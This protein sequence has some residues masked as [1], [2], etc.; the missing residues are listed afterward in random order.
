MSL[1]NRFLFFTLL[2][3]M[4]ILIPS[5]SSLSP[6][7]TE[8]LW[9]FFISSPEKSSFQKAIAISKARGEALD[10][11]TFFTKKETSDS[12]KEPEKAADKFKKAIQL[13]AD[14]NDIMK[15]F[16]DHP[17]KFLFGVSSSAYQYEG[18]LD[19]WNAN[20]AFYR[21]KG[22]KLADHAIDFWNSYENDIQQMKKEL[23]IN[24]FRLSIA[25]DRIQPGIR[26][27][28]RN[29]IDRYVKIIETLKN[30]N[31]EPI[32][33]L[34]H[35]TIPQ[36]FAEIGGFEKAENISYFVDFAK[37]MY[38]ALHE[39]VTYWSTFNAIEGYAFKGY[40][41]LDGPPGDPK[42][43][44]LF[45]TEKVMYNM[46][47][48]HQQCYD[49]IKELFAHYKN[50]SMIPN[51]Q[52]GIQK[53]IV[54]FDPFQNEKTSFCEKYGSK[55]I[56]SFSSLL[57]NTIFFKF[58]K[59]TRLIRYFNLC[60]LDWIGLNIYSNMMMLYAA[61][62]KET[63]EARQTENLNYRNYP[64][65][66]YRAVKIIYEG[67]A[68]PLNIPIIITENGIATKND[69][70]GNEKRTRF[71]QRTLYTIRKLIEEGYPIIGYTPW[72]S[73]DNY[74]WPSKDQP[75]PYNRPYGMF[76]VNFDTSSSHYLERTLKK[77]AEYYRDFITAY[78]GN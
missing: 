69:P 65:G 16:K 44:S 2:F 9:S 20:A 5:Q 30:N 22:F 51:P 15:R 28:D 75:D 48:A 40:Y 72:A 59:P 21:Q 73:H 19:Q 36:W 58:F 53:N 78:F 3:S 26:G 10:L 12:L 52:I 76:S 46:L 56:C 70:S 13:A 45:M 62:Q 11:H 63:V 34:H 18:G 35:Y 25:W 1:K 42:K 54:L 31:I 38:E 8:W 77:G 57:N 29:A 17:E 14:K 67:I 68:Q 4:N 66:I 41:K 64:E 71:F 23:G 50:D 60:K 61:P 33:V 39:H 55:F 49:S 43:K 24:C 74:E 47:Q 32:V 6:S 7:W 37:K 27:W